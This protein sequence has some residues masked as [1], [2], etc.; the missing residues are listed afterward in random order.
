[1]GLR[2]S[3]WPRQVK[4]Y[5]INCSRSLLFV[6]AHFDFGNA[7]IATIA[8]LGKKQESNVAMEGLERFG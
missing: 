4:I 5:P 6:F 7:R 2:S 3:E 8:T 1:M